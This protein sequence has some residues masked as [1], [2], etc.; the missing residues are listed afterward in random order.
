MRI[1]IPRNINTI[2]PKTL[3]LLRNFFFTLLPTIK[4]SVE[5]LT[6]IITRITTAL[7]MLVSKNAN[8]TPVIKASM[9]VAK[10]IDRMFD[11]D[12][13]FNFSL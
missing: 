7:T 1:L 2:P 13:N 3:A 11:N 6:V 10:E 8:V 5:R 4:P 9:L 12:N